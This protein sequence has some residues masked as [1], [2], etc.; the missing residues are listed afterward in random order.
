MDRLQAAAALKK[1]EGTGLTEILFKLEVAVKG[2]TANDARVCLVPPASIGK[3]L[4]P[5]RR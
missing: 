2:L 4:L 5:L 3:C 1:F